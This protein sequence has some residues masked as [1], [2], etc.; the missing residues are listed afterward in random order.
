MQP[1]FHRQRLA[2]YGAVMVR[3]AARMLGEWRPGEVRDVHDEMMRLTL[4]IVAE[5]LFG[6][7]L[8]ADA[9]RFSAALTAVLQRFGQR[10]ASPAFLIPEWVPTAGNRRYARVVR[11]MDE[12][13]YGIIERRR[14]SGEERDDLLSLL[15]HAQH[16][17]DGSRLTD[18]QVRDEAMTLLIAGHETTAIALSWTWYLLAE[19]PEV[20]ATLRD[21]LRTVLGSRLPAAA[22]LP[23]LRYAGMVVNEA[24]RLY[25]PARIVTRQAL[26]DCEIGGHR[27]P[28]GTVVLMSQWVV[29]R[30]P[31]FY[32][33]PDEF[34]PDRWAEGLAKQRPRF[35]YF[36]FGG[37]PRQCIGN[38][39]AT[40]EAV[41]LLAAIAQRFRLTLEPGQHITPWPV[42]TLRPRNG[43]KMRL[44]H[45]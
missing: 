41:L 12:M 6:A 8:G 2:T 25:P 21:E 1:A 13:V 7:D 39:F 28:K 23:N 45:R 4:G 43:V 33:R 42:V 14:K 30:D 20:E 3:H 38:G 19:H 5:S 16:E 15:L 35:A 37:G 31:R 40:M 27:V 22:D 29:H 32:D 10:I 18:K 34:L 11:E 36:P 44:H 26:A 17:D 9:D 24:M